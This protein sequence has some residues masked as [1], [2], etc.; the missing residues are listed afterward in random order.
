MKN[1]LLKS[2][3]IL[4]SGFV[5]G[6]ASLPVSTLV[7]AS[8]TEQAVNINSN[9]VQSNYDTTEL[10]TEIV[11]EVAFIAE[12]YIHFDATLGVFILDN[13][14][15]N[16]LSEVDINQVV[17]QVNATNNQLQASKTEVNNSTQINAVDPSGTEYVVKPVFSRGEGTTS[18]T[19]HWNYAR[20]KLS[21]TSIKNIGSGM[22]VGGLFIPH[23]IVSKACS[24]LGIAIGRVTSGIWFDYNY[25]NGILTGNAG[26]Q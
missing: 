1:K 9:H 5:L 14:I 13:A 11:N 12:Q 3:L 16:V 26:W 6:G 23:P 22:S 25:F 17:A 2:S 21:L 20:V 4:I 10:N 7:F 18:V 19:F 8:E 15:E 24:L